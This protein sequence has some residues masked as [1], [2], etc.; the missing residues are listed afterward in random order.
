MNRPEAYKIISAALE[1]YHALGFQALS[2]KVGSRDT[3]DI[4]AP[5]G[6]RY[7]V[8]ISVAWSDAQ[9]RELVVRGRIDDQNSFR[10]IP[11]EEKICVSPVA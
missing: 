10:S 8:D 4:V 7:T 3:E 2:Q 5:S 6:V 9:H 1:R 11:L